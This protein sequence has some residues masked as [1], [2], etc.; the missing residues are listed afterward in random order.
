MLHIRVKISLESPSYCILLICTKCH[1][2][3][4]PHV[5][6]DLDP[7]NIIRSQ[8]KV[9]AHKYTHG[10]FQHWFH[11]CESSVL[12]KGTAVLLLSCVRPYRQ[13]YKVMICK[14]HYCLNG[15]FNLWTFILILRQYLFPGNWMFFPTGSLCCVWLFSWSFETWWSL[16]LHNLSIWAFKNIIYTFL[17]WWLVRLHI[18]V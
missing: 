7:P 4:F 18:P 12:N 9:T 16:W 5:P 15:L 13:R 10:H 14:N 11:G 8:S 1:L 6:V 2:S 17:L 3:V